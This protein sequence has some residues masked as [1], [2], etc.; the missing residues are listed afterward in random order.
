MYL[1]LLV[2]FCSFCTALISTNKAFLNC[3]KW[4]R[5]IQVKFVCLFLLRWNLYLMKTIPSWAIHQAS[6]VK[7]MFAFF[8]LMVSFCYICCLLQSFNHA[9]AQ[10]H[11]TWET[12]F[13]SFFFSATVGLC[14]PAESKSTRPRVFAYLCLIIVFVW[15]Y[16]V[17]FV[18]N[19]KI[20]RIPFAL[21]CTRVYTAHSH[22][23]SFFPDISCWWPAVFRMLFHDH[24]CMD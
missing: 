2:S 3:V 6:S 14:L 15:V 11:E 19:S 22:H 13:H 8:P 21:L 10:K 9:H 17:A 24:H 12:W 23:I 18:L 1:L 4:K 7:N 16:L 5:E 20:H